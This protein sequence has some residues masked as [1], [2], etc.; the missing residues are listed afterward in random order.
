MEYKFNIKIKK[1]FTTKP[2]IGDHQYYI[3]DLT[4]F[5]KNYLN[6]EKKYNTK[7]IIDKILD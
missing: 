1:I 4:M 7:M 3:T 5:K 2:R 6:K